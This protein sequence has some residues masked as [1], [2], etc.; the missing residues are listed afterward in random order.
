MRRFIRFPVDMFVKSPF[1]PLYEH[2]KKAGEAVKKLEE[3]VQAFCDADTDRV[4]KLCGE[5]SAIEHKADK[6]K[7]SIRE[8][9]PPS[10]L[11][12]VNR[13]DFLAFLKPQD[14][15][16]DSAEDIA[17]LMTLRS[18][19]NLPPDIKEDL[20]QIIKETIKTIDEYEKLMDEISRVIKTSFRTDEVEKALAGISAVE[21]IEHGIDKMG[22]KLGRKIFSIEEEIGAVGVYH[23]SE[24]VK[25]IGEVSDYAARAADMLRVMLSK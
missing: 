21:Q 15:I 4:D 2:A 3:I 1:K 11:L 16:P 6:I 23:L 25:K 22:L 20:I 5:I 24:I 14:S 19:Y 12:P 13:Q 17:G 8:N 18:S 9:L 7:Q 10:M